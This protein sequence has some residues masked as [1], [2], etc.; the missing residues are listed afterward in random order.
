MALNPFL[1]NKNIS[2]PMN[3]KVSRT[4]SPTISPMHDPRQKKAVVQ[5]PNKV[6]GAVNPNPVIPGQNTTPSGEQVYQQGLGQ[7]ALLAKRF[8]KANKPSLVSPTDQ[9]QSPCSQKLAG[10]KKRHFVKGK[11]VSLASSFLAAQSSPAGKSVRSE[12]EH[13]ENVDMS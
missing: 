8:A 12:Q 2:T 10:A 13:D 3:D 5:P 4:P 1:Q 11:P 9:M 6:L 7:K